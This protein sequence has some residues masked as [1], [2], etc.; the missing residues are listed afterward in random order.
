MQVIRLNTQQILALLEPESIN[1]Q[2]NE[3]R[4]SYMMEAMTKK[5][6]NPSSQRSLLT[7]VLKDSSQQSA[8]EI[9]P[10]HEYSTQIIIRPR[11]KFT[12]YS[13]HEK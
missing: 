4:D 5:S 8:L 3:S 11:M 9:D 1:E 7:E 2:D 12:E 13:Q 10:P 6:N